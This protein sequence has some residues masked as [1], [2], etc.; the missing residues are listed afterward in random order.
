[1]WE[2]KAK[3]FKLVFK[4]YK[5]YKIDHRVPLLL[6]LWLENKKH[7]KDSKKKKKTHYN[8]L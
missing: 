3:K 6:I 8:A 7:N 2:T 4:S 5:C 1:M